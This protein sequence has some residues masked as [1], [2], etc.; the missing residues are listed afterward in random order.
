M[1]S[2]LLRRG[3]AHTS[4]LH[5]EYGNIFVDFSAANYN[6]VA[7]SLSVPDDIN[8]LL[9]YH[10]AVGVDMDFSSGRFRHTY[11]GSCI[12]RDEGTLLLF[13]KDGIY[14]AWNGH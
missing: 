10:C 9:I 14:Q 1:F 6:W 2:G 5:P 13:K 11:F 8:A 12:D 3:K 4:T 7:M